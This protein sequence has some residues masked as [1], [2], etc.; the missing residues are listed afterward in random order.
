MR[1]DPMMVRSFYTAIIIRQ[2][3][4]W[5]P[6]WAFPKASELELQQRL[7]SNQ[8]QLIGGVPAWRLA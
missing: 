5:N 1:N 2:N 3:M 7:S 4:L 6:A 8:N